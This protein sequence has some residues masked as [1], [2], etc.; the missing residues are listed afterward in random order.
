MNIYQK[1]NKVRMELQAMHLKK[2]GYNKFS[3]F[4]YYELDDFLPNAKLMFNRDG[5]FSKFD[6]LPDGESASLLI[7]NCDEVT[8]TMLFTNPVAEVNIGAKADGTGGAQPIQN[9]GGKNTYLRRYL[10]INALELTEKDAV[11]GLP[12]DLTT[13]KP[14]PVKKDE[15]K[16]NS[17][18]KIAL[19]QIDKI[20]NLIKS[21]KIDSDKMKKYF[22]VTAIEQLNYAQATQAIEQGGK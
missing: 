14:T 12:K 21:G 6:I 20:Q 8:E 3:K 5:L 11:D 7:V 22:N 1:L 4:P 17:G 13:P 16:G 2:S 10:Y 9:L 19:S 15:P 18:A